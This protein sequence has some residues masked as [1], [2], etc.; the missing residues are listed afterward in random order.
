MLKKVSTKLPIISCLTGLITNTRKF[1][2][3]D[4]I[5]RKFLNHSQGSKVLH[6]LQLTGELKV[7]LLQLRTKVNADHAGHS[8]PLD[9]WKEDTKS[10]DTI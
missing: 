3:T 1:L 10:L 5:K 7:L 2:D 6:Q 9:Q 4:H 8:Q